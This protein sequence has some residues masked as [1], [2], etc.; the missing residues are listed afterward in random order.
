[1]PTRRKIRFRFKSG[2]QPAARPFTRSTG[3]ASRS[4]GEIPR[5]TQSLLS[6][7][8]FSRSRASQPVT[9]SAAPGG[10]ERGRPSSVSAAILTRQGP[11]KTVCPGRMRCDAQGLRLPQQPQRFPLPHRDNAVGKGNLSSLQLQH[12]VHMEIADVLFPA[13]HGAAIAI[14][15]ARL[16]TASGVLSSAD[17]GS[18]ADTPGTSSAFFSSISAAS[19]SAASSAASN[20]AVRAMFSTARGWLPQHRHYPVPPGDCGSYRPFHW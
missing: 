17:T 1:M 15:T 7:L 3:K 12:G 16:R 10:T 18:A 11:K 8:P 6:V 4:I 14:C 13:R 9:L 19:W 5:S 20:A 2:D